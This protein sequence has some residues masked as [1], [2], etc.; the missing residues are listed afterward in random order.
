M[1]CFRTSFCH[2]AR[3]DLALTA[4]RWTSR[5]ARFSSSGNS[6]WE[7]SKSKVGSSG[8]ATAAVEI[9]DVRDDGGDGGVADGAAPVAGADVELSGVADEAAPLLEV[10]VG[11]GGVADEATPLLEV[12][13][14]LGGDLLLHVGVGVEGDAELEC[15]KKEGDGGVADEAAPLPAALRCVALNTECHG[16]EGAQ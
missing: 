14:E 13:V 7:C 5:R 9:A 16:A 2:R 11:P 10:D 1:W 3:L 8:S 4:R 12:D 6:P 15:R